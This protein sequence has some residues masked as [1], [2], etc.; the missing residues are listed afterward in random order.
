MR[1]RGFSLL[2]VLVALAI[3]TVALVGLIR[4]TAGGAENR[5]Q[6]ENRTLAH[7]VAL[8]RITELRLAASWPPPGDSEGVA[9]MG[10]QEWT[11]RQEVKATPDEDVR[12]VR[13]R[14][15]TQ[16]TAGLALLTAYLVQPRGGSSGAN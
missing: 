3:V 12:E 5:Y 8:N 9:E 14:V 13:L 16:D 6:L 4:L 10:G 7:W 15:G 11:W 2:E 1:V